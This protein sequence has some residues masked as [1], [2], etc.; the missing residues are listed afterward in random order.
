MFK[1]KLPEYLEQEIWNYA[2]VKLRNGVYVTQIAKTDPRREILQ[3]IPKITLKI[4]TLNNIKYK[5][6]FIRLNKKFYISYQSK[7]FIYALNLHVQE[8]PVDEENLKKKLLSN[9]GNYIYKL[10]NNIYC[11]NL[12]DNLIENV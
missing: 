5:V 7:E 1:R 8:Y 11:Y 12:Y 9:I 4:T 6:P 3:K 2:N 10:D